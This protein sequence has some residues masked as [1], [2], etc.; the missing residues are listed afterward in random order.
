M[1]WL[2]CAFIIAWVFTI[3]IGVTTAAPYGWSSAWSDSSLVSGES[4]LRWYEVFKTDEGFL[5]VWIDGDLRLGVRRIDVGSE[6]ID[7][8]SPRFAELGWSEMPATLGAIWEGDLLTLYYLQS[9]GDE[10]SL[11]FRQFDEKG[12]PVDVLDGILS[13]D[14]KVSDLEVVASRRGH[15]LFWSQKDRGALQIRGVV[16][17][18]DGKSIE[19]GPRSI[20]VTDRV[21]RFPRAIAME[22]IRRGS[23]S[24]VVTWSDRRFENMMDLKVCRIGR[25]LKCTEPVLLDSV[26]YENDYG[27]GVLKKTSDG[28]RAL[29][30]WNGVGL[31]DKSPIGIAYIAGAE[32]GW[33][34]DEEGNSALVVLRRCVLA[35]T[36]RSKS[37]YYRVDFDV[38]DDPSCSY[39]SPARTRELALAWSQLKTNPRHPRREVV[40]LLNLADCT[41]QEKFFPDQTRGQGEFSLNEPADDDER[42]EE[43]IVTYGFKNVWRVKVQYR[44]VGE[45]TSLHY[46]WEG[47][48]G[49]ETGLFYSHTLEKPSI[50][51]WN[52]LGLQRENLLA[53][54]IAQICLAAVWAA[55]RLGRRF[56]PLAAAV[57]AAWALHSTDFGRRLVRGRPYK[58]LYSLGA[59]FALVVLMTE[60][61]K[62]GIPCMDCSVTWS[63]F[64]VATVLT[65]AM[66]GFYLK[67]TG[68][69]PGRDFL[70][71]SGYVLLWGFY[72]CYIELLFIP[73]ALF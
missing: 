58:T 65:G 23:E 27:A 73:L 63:Q 29:V 3:G 18:P 51:R 9:A 48:R 11:G 53:S 37:P 36:E 47:I 69:S 57:F 41:S 61:I 34:A 49:D 26:L 55:T 70:S 35:V 71:A 43:G 40:G 64:G 44:G 14:E 30:V 52:V 2:V 56:V 20:A 24:I 8:K 32:L 16:V 13:F 59:I 17:D 62:T 25:D 67:L 50:H 42:P 33:N 4:G 22:G 15:Y 6:G 10:W 68:S 54:G 39:C 38:S 45:E 31:R 72:T 12:T 7:M 21:S 1:R 66:S 46:F 60:E 5:A 28:R 19:Q